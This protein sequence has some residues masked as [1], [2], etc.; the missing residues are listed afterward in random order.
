M[1]SSVSLRNR[2]VVIF[3]FR[4]GL[5]RMLLLT[6]LLL[7][8]LLLRIVLLYSLLLSWRLPRLLRGVCLARGHRDIAEVLSLRMSRVLMLTKTLLA[9][10]LLHLM[11]LWLRY[12]L[13]L[14]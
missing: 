7:S 3:R 14:T 11:L 13:P 10:M 8:N 6:K 2:H 12:I 5:Q 1:D 4:F 9:M